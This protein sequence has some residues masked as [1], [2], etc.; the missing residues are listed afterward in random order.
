MRYHAV[1]ITSDIRKD[2]PAE[3]EGASTGCGLDMAIGKTFDTLADMV[4]FVAR[5]FGLPEAVADWDVES[6]DRLCTSKL[7]ANH[8]EAQNGGWFEPTAAEMAA[9][10]RGTFPLYSENVSVRYLRCL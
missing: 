7:V 1:S 4:R 5:Q 2:D 8:S 3:G 10:R 9:W 6:P